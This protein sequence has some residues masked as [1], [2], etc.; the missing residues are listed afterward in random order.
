MA[1]LVN[2]LF[3]QQLTLRHETL[4]DKVVRLLNSEE[5]VL[6]TAR[7][8]RIEAGTNNASKGIG[9]AWR[10]GLLDVVGVDKQT[11]GGHLPGRLI[12]R[13]GVSEERLA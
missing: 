9:E 11:R 13:P 4:V 5:G 12:A 6:A 3:L 10:V 1:N 7:C 8:R 2:V